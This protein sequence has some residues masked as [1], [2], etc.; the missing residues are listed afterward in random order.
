MEVGLYFMV[1]G[2]LLNGAVVILYL[3]FNPIT[4]VVGEFIFVHLANAFITPDIN[5]VRVL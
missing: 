4:I 1:L 2:V 5:S 3:L